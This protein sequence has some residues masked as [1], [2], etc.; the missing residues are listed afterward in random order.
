MT[1]A[2]FL[3]NTEVVANDCWAWTG[4]K[5]THGYGYVYIEGKL[6]RAHR[7]SYEL[8]V[9]PIPEKLQL[10]HLCRKRDCVNPEHLE[11]VTCKEN[12]AR[13]PLHIGKI[14]IA[15][16]LCKYGHELTFD[17]KHFGATSKTRRRCKTCHRDRER[18]RRA[19]KKEAT[20][21]F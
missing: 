11:P 18:I 21:E 10:D 6:R 14:N 8:W 1:K 3:T 13:S 17:A 19:V 9:G 12:I 4:T 5:N 7:V 16:T 2:E 15:K 20:N